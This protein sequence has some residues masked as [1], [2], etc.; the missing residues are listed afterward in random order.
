MGHVRGWITAVWLGLTTLF[1][2]FAGLP[3]RF[4]TGNG[5][6]WG[7]F[8]RRLWGP[9][10]LWFAGA[11]VEV[12]SAKLPD[13]PLVFA[14]NHESALDICVLF[15]VL[16][17]NVRFIAKR[18]LFELPIFGWYMRI[19]G[20]VPVD[21]ANRSNAIQTLRRAGEMI[22]GGTSIIAFPEG[23]RSKDGLVHAFKKGPFVVAKEAGVPVVPV[24]IAGAGALNPKGAIFA[25]PGTIRVSL[26]EAV[27]PADFPDRTDLL[28]EVRRRVIAQHR[29]LG[30]LGG[31]PDKAV[32]A[33]GLEGAAAE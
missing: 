8:G 10:I 28:V 5:D 31:N 29:A 33:A 9:S 11:R 6:I 23:T 22:R 15:K 17:R 32:A 4:L 3:V 30:G 20:H 18:E 27:N 14:A 21:R 7:W 24:A 13:G 19:G 12:T 1:F 25:L 26:G 2:I 16:P